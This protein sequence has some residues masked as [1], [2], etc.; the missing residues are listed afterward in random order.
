MLRRLKRRRTLV[1][2]VAI[3][4]VAA[5][6]YPFWIPV[7]RVEGARLA[8]LAKRAPPEGL[9][10]KAPKST[11]VPTTQIPFQAAKAAARHTPNETGMVS[12]QWAPKA[13][14]GAGATLLLTLVPAEAEAKK[15]LTEALTGYTSSKTLK[16]DGYTLKNRFEVPG[17]P[18]AHAITFVTGGSGS[19]EVGE[20]VFRVGRAVDVVIVDGA[21]SRSQ[22]AVTTFAQRQHQLLEQELPGFSLV[23]TVLP[24]LA[25]GLYWGVAVALGLLAVSVPP[26]IRW[27]RRRRRLTRAEV[28]RRERL[29]RERNAVKRQARAPAPRRPA[30]R[31]R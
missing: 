11:P 20:V 4:V 3:L 7:S 18:G 15:V 17:V 27:V 31:R 9:S 23:A 13:T 30:G 21:G 19:T 6:V 25:S 5:V 28:R 12:V 10:V 1:V 8:Q 24:P 22:A 2:A 16:A 14:N 29:A 26:T